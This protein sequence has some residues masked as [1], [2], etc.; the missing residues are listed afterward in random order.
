L[1]EAALE[2]ALGILEPRGKVTLVSAVEVPDVP[3][4][5]Y[6]PP[7]VVPDYEEA[8]DNLIPYAR[9][10]LEGIA[11]KLMEQG[12]TVRIEAAIGDPAVVITETAEKFQVD[13]IVMSTHGRSGLSRWLFGS[14]TNKVLSAKPCPVYVIPSQEISNGKH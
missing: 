12:F 14:V 1:A 6:Y 8:K 7:A 5:G 11:A 13:A 2:H 9:H 10:Y 4:Y 3:V